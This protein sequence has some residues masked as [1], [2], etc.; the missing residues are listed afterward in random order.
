MDGLSSAGGVFAV[1]SLTI[2]LGKIVHNAIKFFH[3]VRDTPREVIRLVETLNSFQR[4]LSHVEILASQYSRV[5][6]LPGSLSVLEY[7][8]HNSNVKLEVLTELVA[9]FETFLS[10]PHRIQRS[11]GS[12]KIARKKELVQH[13]ERHVQDAMTMLQSA[14]MINSAISINE[15]IDVLDGQSALLTKPTQNIPARQCIVYNC[16]TKSRRHETSIA[17]LK[18]W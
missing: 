11:W 7:A 14:I 9:E 12:V 4:S 17:V 18:F 2:E 1:V 13:T 10:R 15:Y 8:L 16:N 5:P 6:K 3:D